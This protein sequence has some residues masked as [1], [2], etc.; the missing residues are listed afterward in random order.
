VSV[1]LLCCNL[2]VALLIILSAGAAQT[3]AQETAFIEILI[4]KERPIQVPF[5]DSDC[6]RAEKDQRYLN[7]RL[8]ES[9]GKLTGFP[10]PRRIAAGVWACKDGTIVRTKNEILVRALVKLY[11]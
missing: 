5:K 9:V 4:R 11:R 7:M 2:S 3:S 1:K 6:K 10:E 8:R